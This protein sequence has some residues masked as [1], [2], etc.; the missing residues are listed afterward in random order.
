M[1]RLRFSGDGWMGRGGG[2]YS[3]GMVVDHGGVIWR[4]CNMAVVMVV[5]GGRVVDLLVLGGG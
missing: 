4:W 3:S 1:H 5:D 2:T